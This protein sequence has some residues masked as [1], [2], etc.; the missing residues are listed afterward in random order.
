MAKR[1]LTEQEQELIQK[2]HG[3]HGEVAVFPAGNEGLFIVKKPDQFAFQRLQDGRAR[4]LMPAAKNPVSL[5]S[6]EREYVLTCCVY[7][8]NKQERPKILDKYPAMVSTITG[9]LNEMAGDDIE[10]LSGN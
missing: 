3:E 4:A 10:E 1:T 5:N 6:T 8:E 7:P 9:R 2:L